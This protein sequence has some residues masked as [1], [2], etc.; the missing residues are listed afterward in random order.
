M[1]ELHNV[2]LFFMCVFTHTALLHTTLESTAMCLAREEMGV[3]TY[4]TSSCVGEKG[5]MSQWKAVWREGMR[6]KKGGIC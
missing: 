2:A 5:K 3:L 1:K 6:K 4:Q